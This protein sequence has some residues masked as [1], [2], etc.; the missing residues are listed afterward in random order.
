VTEYRTSRWTDRG[1]DEERAGEE[2]SVVYENL[3][4]MPRVWVAAKADEL[5]DDRAIETIRYAQFPD[6]RPFDP[7][8]SVLIEPGVGAQ[9]FTPGPWSARLVSVED[10]RMTVD[11]STDNGGYLVLSEAQYPGWRA[12]IDGDIVP[13]RRVDVMFQGVAVPAGRHTVVFEFASTTLRAGIAISTLAVA[14]ALFLC[15]GSV[16]L[17]APVH[18]GAHA[19]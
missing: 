15:V 6:G 8:R 13:V 4:A 7:M 19:G 17:S 18:P 3:R 14:F 10:T 16:R 5:P 12:R 9:S 11:V 2:G 1:S